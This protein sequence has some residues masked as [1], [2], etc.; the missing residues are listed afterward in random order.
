MGKH[1]KKAYFALVGSRSKRN[2]QKY[3]FPYFNTNKE[4]GKWILKIYVVKS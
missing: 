2:N 4:N 1:T 3:A